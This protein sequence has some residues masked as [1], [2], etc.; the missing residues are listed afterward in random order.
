MSAWHE[1]APNVFV[2]RYLPVD[3]TISVVRGRDGLLLVDTGGSPAEAA[4]IAQ[5]LQDLGVPARWVVNTHAHFDHTFGNQRF[6]SDLPIYGHHL[7]PAHLD[8]HERPRLAKWRTGISQEP[9]RDWQDVVVTAPTQLV[10]ER[11]WLDLG[12]VTVELIPLEPGHTDDDLVVRVPAVP[13][14]AL[15]ATSA[16]STWIVGDVLEEPGP[17][18]YGSG[19]F[20]MRWPTTLAGFLDEVAQGDLI[21]PGHGRPV[22]RAFGLAQQAVVAGTADLIREHH[23]AGHTVEQALASRDGWAYPS[24]ALSLAVDRGYIDLDDHPR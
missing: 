19:C 3:T 14:A 7:L 18:M 13:D 2:R 8:E 21:V 6:S 23:A 24:E 5:D 12:G 20:P 10:H 22:S 15:A 9:H 17:P 1:V 11:S 16:G 4:Q